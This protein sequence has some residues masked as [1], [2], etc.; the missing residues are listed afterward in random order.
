MSASVRTDNPLAGTRLRSLARSLHARLFVSTAGRIFAVRGRPAH[1]V[2]A[3]RLASIASVPSAAEAPTPLELGISLADGELT[4]GTL[5][6]ISVTL[7]LW[8]NQLDTE[9][10]RGGPRREQLVAAERRELAVLSGRLAACRQWRG[11]AAAG[12][13]PAG[14]TYLLG[15][16]AEARLAEAL[17]AIGEDRPPLQNWLARLVHW[18]AGPRA[19]TRFLAAAGSLAAN[20]KPTR[21][22]RDLLAL[23][24]ATVATDGGVAPL[25]QRLL[26]AEAGHANAALRA[27][28]A[29]SR[30]PGYEALLGALAQLPHVRQPRLFAAVRQLLARGIGL[31]DVAWAAEHHLLA[32][33]AE[34]KLP[35][36]RVRR[37]ADQFAA[38]GLPLDPASLCNIA[39]ELASRADESLALRWLH[40]CDR[41]PA[42]SLPPRLRRVL[43]AAFSDC[44]LPALHRPWMTGPLEQ[45]LAAQSPLGSA[46]LSADP[47]A[48]LEQLAAWQRLIGQPA[49]TPKSVRRLLEREQSR[50]GERVHLARQL[51]AN[52][53]CGENIH[54]RYE[55]LCVQHSA[56]PAGT[57][58]LARAATAAAV[59]GAIEALRTLLRR[60]GEEAW[61]LE[62]SLALPA[63]PQAAPDRLACWVAEM[64]DAARQLLREVTAAW[65]AT[66]PGYKLA[67]AGN[68]Q[69]LAQAA[70]AGIDVQR[71]LRGEHTTA[72]I[73]GQPVEI[74]LAADPR[75]V[76]LMGDYFRTCL[77]L[78]DCNQLSPLFNAHDANKQVVLAI[79]RLPSGKRQVVARQLIAVSSEWQLIGYR[80][81]R[82][83]GEGTSQREAC[84]AAIAA[85][86]GR[87]ARRCGL[88]L[89]D[90][91][92]PATLSSDKWLDD[93][94]VPWHPAARSA[95]QGV[96]QATSDLE[97]QV[98]LCLPCAPL[99]ACGD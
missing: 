23:V 94:T 91:G 39:G 17:G 54:R 16:V 14:A 6:A 86:C 92:Q 40:W 69:W 53:S 36:G 66:G 63:H 33:L 85:Y 78:G 45:W 64:D 79:G 50:H 31:A 35:P 74:G 81:Y 43:R 18:L 46:S 57:A 51:A 19:M 87:L 68:R 70:A 95:C 93:G 30:Q 88:P 1:L 21:K 77:S 55:R 82:V 90:A 83:F 60:A 47:Q 20:S 89:G 71:W 76:F 56:E 15:E 13:E 24:A 41:W 2:L 61:R 5:Q 99:V 29:Q 3:R 34:S 58:K 9:S 73:G 72:D 11:R 42:K 4:D 8:R 12:D 44:V 97:P 10:R 38:H 98:W 22:S 28:V 59:M 52:P 25:P 75:D 7:D 49:A 32:P 65:Q 37:L 27:L 96:P 67:L 80:C 84:L 26:Q 62:T 48:C